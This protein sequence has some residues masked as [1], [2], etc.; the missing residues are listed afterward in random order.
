MNKLTPAPW[1]THT[2]EPEPLYLT[3]SGNNSLEE[4]ITSKKH[5]NKHQNNH[6]IR[7]QAEICVTLE[8]NNKTSL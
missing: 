6:L 2:T 1:L 4:I 5:Q 8:G 3:G 7:K